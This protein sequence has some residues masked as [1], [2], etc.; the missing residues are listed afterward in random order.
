MKQQPS[1]T[2]TTITIT[3]GNQSNSSKNSRHNLKQHLQKISIKQPQQTEKEIFVN[4]NKECVN[5]S[6]SEQ[7]NYPGIQKQPDSKKNY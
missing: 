3:H 4:I 1:S 2:K 6:A 5:Q 7:Q